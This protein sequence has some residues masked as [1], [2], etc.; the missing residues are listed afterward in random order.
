MLPSN[1]SNNNK[2][3]ITEDVIYFEKQGIDR[4]C[5]LHC[6]NSILQGPFYNEV[7]LTI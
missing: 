5:G 2:Q 7:L 4:L 6:V 3:I 1:K